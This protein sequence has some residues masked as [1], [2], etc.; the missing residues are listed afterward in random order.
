MSISLK[1]AELFQEQSLEYSYRE[2]LQAKDWVLVPLTLLIVYFILRRIKV[3]LSSEL[4]PYLIPA[5]FFRL[6]GLAL[7]L[8][9]HLVIY[10]GGVD[11][12]TYYW[13]ARQLNIL[14]KLD[15][16]TY[17]RIMV[18]AAGRYTEADFN[19]ELSKF[20]FSAQESIPIK[21]TSL[22]NLCTGESYIV[23]SLIIGLFA[24]GGCWK[25]FQVFQEDY[26]EY[27][28]GLAITCLFVPSVVFWT[29]VISKE[30]FCFGAMGYFFFAFYAIVFKGKRN[31]WLFL[32]LVIN[33]YL[34]FQIKVYILLSFVPIT[35]LFIVNKFSKHLK[36]PLL[37]YFAT[38]VLILLLGYLLFSGY[39]NLGD[40]LQG[41]SMDL[42][43]ENA[44]TTYIYLTQEGFA[45][46]RYTLGEFDPSLQGLLALG[47]A[48]INV[49][50]FRPYFW[51]ANKAITLLASAESFITFL[52]TLW[53]I[54]KTGLLKTFKILFTDH[55]VYS[56]ILFAIVFA[57]M[58]GITSGNF[59]TLM[60]YK[61]PM[62]PFYYSALWII[63]M[64]GRIKPVQPVAEKP[65]ND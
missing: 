33:A 62:M 27:R 45:E 22:I 52:F 11:S 10:T 23:T 20:I 4:K 42:L 8:F 44:K 32:L 47:P 63:Y 36:E 12:I 37:R 38:P 49:T 29:S 48:G 57:M 2:I 30:I 17:Y 51:E 3:Q 14:R 64:K 15:F 6:F 13:S 19:I 5:Y 54:A 34:L 46:S 61:I 41:Y 24:F 25:M 1:Q 21:V 60:R 53:V 7:F 40:S 58:V 31:L 9:H 59:G 56:S 18:S 16:D 43:L 28:K 55:M 39:G 35:V 50:L 65:A 26:P